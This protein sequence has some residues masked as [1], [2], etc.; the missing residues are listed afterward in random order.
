MLG[1]L[2]GDETKPEKG[3]EMIE[4][5]AFGRLFIDYTM[6]LG[7]ARRHSG[8]SELGTEQYRHT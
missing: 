5:E 4:V 6:K 2:V 7:V 1:S 3:D 8:C